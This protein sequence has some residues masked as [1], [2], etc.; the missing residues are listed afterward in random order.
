ME[1]KENTKID[2]KSCGCII[3]DKQKVLLV[4]QTK[5]HWGFP[6]GHVEEN[7]TEEETA[8]REVKE[9]TN[10]DVQIDKSKRYTMQYMTDKGKLKQVVLFIAKI[11][12]GSMLPQESEVAEIKW[13]SYNEAIQTIT[14]DNAKILFKEVLKELDDTI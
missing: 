5:G 2:E 10:L 7:E 13:F 4:K 14:Y 9:E 11:I 3:M 6:K 8:K 12:D 1:L